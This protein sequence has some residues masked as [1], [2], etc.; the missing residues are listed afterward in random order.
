MEEEE[1]HSDSIA[2]I[3]LKFENLQN[4]MVGPE[5]MPPRPTTAPPVLIG[6]K[7]TNKT[8]VVQR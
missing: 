6:S 2:N 3:I 7:N 5:D 1:C 8:C 4:G